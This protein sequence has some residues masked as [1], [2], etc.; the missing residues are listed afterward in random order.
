M[1]NLRRTAIR[2]ADEL[3]LGITAAGSPQL[4][5]MDELKISPEARY[6][7]M[8]DDYQVLTREQLI[9]GTQVHAQVA[10]RDLATSPTGWHPGCHRCSRSV[11]APR[12]GSAPTP[13]TPAT[14]PW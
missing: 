2:E 6:E 10:D 8:L 12:T 11:P 5:D 1:C 7:R 9:C 13:A 3:G 4:V 14:G